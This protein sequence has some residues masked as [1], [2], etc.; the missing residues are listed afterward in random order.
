MSFA[1]RVTEARLNIT[2]G[3]AGVLSVNWLK[4]Q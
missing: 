2:A 4:C 1:L 3:T